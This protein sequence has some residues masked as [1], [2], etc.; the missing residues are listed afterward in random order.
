MCICGLFPEPPRQKAPSVSRV[1]LVLA[2]RNRKK[3]GATHQVTRFYQSKHLHILGLGVRAVWD[4]KSKPGTL[5]AGRTS[6]KIF[7]ESV[8][9][10]CHQ[11]SFA[12]LIEAAAEA[13]LD[14]SALEHETAN[15]FVNHTINRHGNEKAE[16]DQGQLPITEADISSTQYSQIAQLCLIGIKRQNE[17]LIAYCKHFDG[18]TSIYLEEI[19]NSRK[20]KTLRSKTMYK[21]QDIVTQETFLQ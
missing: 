19:L 20:N 2:S 12:W 17:T 7:F 11:Q 1:S 21:K 5:A 10:S 13:G 8:C 18:W 4:V 16:R 6:R 9:K 3:P 15:Y 14:I